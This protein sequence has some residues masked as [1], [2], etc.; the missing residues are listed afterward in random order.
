MTLI[1]TGRER[2]PDSAMYR[3]HFI[4]EDKAKYRLP[5]DENIKILQTVIDE[6]RR[7]DP[8]QPVGV[9]KENLKTWKALGLNP[10]ATCLSGP[11]LE[12]TIS[13]FVLD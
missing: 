11:C 8:Q 10:A 9:C 12:N 2:F 1:E 4:K 3:Q 13:Q 6:I 5:Y 7:H